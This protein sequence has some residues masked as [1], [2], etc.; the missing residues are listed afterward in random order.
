MYKILIFEKNNFI[1]EA[2]KYLPIS[3]LKFEVLLANTKEYALE[4]VNSDKISLVL[5]DG[6]VI[7]DLNTDK[8]EAQFQNL[9]RVKLPPIILFS[10][11]KD[12][13]IQGFHHCDIK[14]TYTQ[15]INYEELLET[16]DMILVSDTFINSLV[17]YHE[18]EDIALMMRNMTK[19]IA[20]QLE[21]DDSKYA[22]IVYALKILSTVA[23][24]GSLHKALKFC[25]DMGVH[26]NILQL[27]KNINHPKTEE[28]Q[29]IYAM[30]EIA[31]AFIANKNLDEVE[32]PYAD[33]ELV[34]NIKNI[35]TE[36]FIIVNCMA[37]VEIA[38]DMFLNFVFS[39]NLITF[40]KMN[41][42]FSFIRMHVTRFI[43][44]GLIDSRNMAIKMLNQDD[45]ISYITF[46]NRNDKTLA[47][48]N[49]FPS[50]N[51]DIE[52]SIRQI[53]GKYALVVAIKV[54]FA[55]DNNEINALIS[56]FSNIQKISS[57]EYVRSLSNINISDELQEMQ[58]IEKAWEREVL[59][60]NLPSISVMQEIGGY[61]IRYGEI[62]ENLFYEFKGISYSLINLGSKILAFDTKTDISYEKLRKV[63]YL[64]GLLKEDLS[65]WREKIFI[66]Q[67]TWNI[68]YLDASMLVSCASIE[69]ILSGKKLFESSEDMIF[70]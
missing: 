10:Q 46:L 47:E 56:E 23:K 66:E 22:L 35:I 42:Y 55:T 30:F 7:K 15:P 36:H 51:K 21:L 64:I 37:D 18:S 13:S 39:E 48:Q 11:T 16:M 6:D 44:R 19:T 26:Q 54:I 12:S 41:E 8:D 4:L 24:S 25:L 60:C 68:H 2:I 50:P 45:R 3:S 20:V 62:I 61:I 29:F 70:F 34:S 40:D 33:A 69:E 38:W 27:I 9:L 53:D 28:E 63:M 52:A 31:K 32:L 65:G 5:L 43:E 67:S 1:Q 57:K 59:F 14:K 58:E 49:I 17:K